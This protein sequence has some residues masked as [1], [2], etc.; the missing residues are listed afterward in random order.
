MKRLEMRSTASDRA[1]QSA[2]TSGAG[3]DSEAIHKDFVVAIGTRPGD[4]EA[5]LAG[6]RVLLVDDENMVRRSIARLLLRLGATVEAVSHAS[7][8]LA[9]LAQGSEFDL[10]LTDYEMPGCNGLEF[11]EQLSALYPDLPVVL[12]S[13]NIDYTQL[14]DHHESYL[15]GVLHKPFDHV[16]LAETL[17][18]VIVRK[19]AR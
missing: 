10:V 15:R 1:D 19:V 12:C 8:G 17:R 11:A 5:E 6:L 13:G 2:P 9:M 4:R 3:L 16:E 14:E 7:M 18:Q